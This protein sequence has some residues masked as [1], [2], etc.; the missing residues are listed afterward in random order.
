ML[1]LFFEI[2]SIII[3][4]FFCERMNIARLCHDMY[5]FPTQN[6]SRRNLKGIRELL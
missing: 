3:Y 5:I 6:Y 4:H 2:G 1:G